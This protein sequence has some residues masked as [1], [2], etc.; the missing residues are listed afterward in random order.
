MLTYTSAIHKAIHLDWW[1]CSAS[2]SQSLV[3]RDV[4]QWSHLPSSKGYNHSEMQ[5]KH[6]KGRVCDHNEPMKRTTVEVLV[7]DGLQSQHGL[8]SIAI[9][10]TSNYGFISWSCK[11]SVVH[12]VRSCQTLWL[13][14]YTLF[15]YIWYNQKQIIYNQIPILHWAS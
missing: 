12:N 2:C 1:R 10:E 4:V 9:N 6:R 13:Q 14:T 7:I 3:A 15:A 5:C 11:T 8:E